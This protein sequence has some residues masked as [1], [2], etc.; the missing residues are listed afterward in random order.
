VWLSRQRDGWTPGGA[1]DAAA[2]ALSG[3]WRLQRRK[4]DGSSEAPDLGVETRPAPGARLPQRTSRDRVSPVRGA[5]V[6]TPRV[7][8]LRHVPRPQGGRGR[9]RLTL[10]AAVACLFPGQGSQRVGMGRDLAQAFESARRTFE[11]ADE[12]LGIA[13]SSLCFEGPAETLARTEHAQP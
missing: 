13:L 9:G 8:P 4:T 6:A 11:E 5:D 7:P 10:R 3:R 2:R 1:G 12:C